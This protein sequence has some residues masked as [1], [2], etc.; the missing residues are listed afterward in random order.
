M[1]L[2]LDLWQVTAKDGVSRARVAEDG[3]AAHTRLL[4]CI[5]G[6]MACL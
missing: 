3:M 6:Q 1:K 5:H 2:P 4:D